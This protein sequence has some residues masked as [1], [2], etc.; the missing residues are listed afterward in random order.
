MILR[1]LTEYSQAALGLTRYKTTMVE[2][3]IITALFAAA[4]LQLDEALTLADDAP[5]VAAANLAVQQR[6]SSVAT[7]SALSSNPLIQ[8]QP[9]LRTQDGVARA[10]GQVTVQQSFNL[11]DLQGI[12]RQLASSDAAS[13]RAG[14]I[15]RRW[16]RRTTVARAWL[17]LWA[18]QAVTSAAKLEAEA[19]RELAQRLERVARSGGVTL[20]E[21]ASAKAF[22]AEAEG[23]VLLWEGQAFDTSAELGM[24]LGLGELAQV[25]GDPADLEAP[26]L[27]EVAA[28]KALAM[29]PH[30]RLLE[31]QHELARARADEAKA[32]WG[33]ALHLS[34]LGGY[35]AQAQWVSSVGV[36][37]T[38][39]VFERGQAE[40]S[41]QHSLMTRLE[42]ETSS[43][44]RKAAVE[45]LVVQHELEHS[46]E[47]HQLVH[48]QQLPAAQ[49]ALRLESKRFAQGE[50]TLQELLLVRRQA[51]AAL[52]GEVLARAELLAARVRAREFVRVLKE[53]P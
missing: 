28:P 16:V 15:E 26:A 51:F 44:K 36:G 6:R 23:A 2:A 17:S 30:V 46:F 32:M 12:R 50:T 37:L 52:Q 34:L 18:A 24:L 7:I 42:G 9:G 35:E 3:V 33:S 19:A 40:A 20:A 29:H 1:I 25:A 39:P 5:D 4:P 13:A 45:L 31:T 53:R 43:A 47:V 27:D 22:A 49:E 14:A 10:E 41:A 11:A 21:V 48:D 8:L 38:L